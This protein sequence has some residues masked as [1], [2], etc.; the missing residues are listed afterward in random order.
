MH[1]TNDDVRPLS[2]FWQ[3]VLERAQ[4][5]PTDYG[6]SANGNFAAAVAH[7][8]CQDWD[9]RAGRLGTGKLSRLM[10]V[11]HREA[12]AAFHECVHAGLIE[13][14]EPADREAKTSTLI[15]WVG[16]S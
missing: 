11:P 4:N 5:D 1:D 3:R 9:R 16:S 10:G 13:I 12:A 8:A 2:P 6:L 15:R 14:V 7:A